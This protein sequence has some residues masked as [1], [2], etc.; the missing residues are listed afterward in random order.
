[1]LHRDEYLNGPNQSPDLAS[2]FHKSQT[3]IA[4]S[5]TLTLLVRVLGAAIFGTLSDM[6]GKKWVMS[7][8]LWI[9]AVVQVGTAFSSSFRGFVG[10]RNIFRVA[11][12]GIWVCL[13]QLLL[14]TCRLKLEG[15]FH[16]F[17]RMDM[18]G[19]RTCR[20]GKCCRCPGC[21]LIRIQDD[22]FCWGVFYGSHS[23]YHNVY[24]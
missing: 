15:Y 23:Y 21:K 16:E 1:L 22:L 8:D 19:L 5:V 9:L 10:I 6:F 17:C 3:T 11:T 12:G 4:L 14:K 20:D 7:I 18:H 24:P 2:A 13:Q